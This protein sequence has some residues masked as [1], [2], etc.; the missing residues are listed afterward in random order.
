MSDYFAL[1]K[2]NDVD[3]NSVEILDSQCPAS[4]TP[5]EFMKSQTVIPFTMMSASEFAD[6][7]N[8]HVYGVTEVWIKHISLDPEGLE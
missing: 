4:M 2:A 1:F 5:Y 3:R 7:C 6:F 8:D